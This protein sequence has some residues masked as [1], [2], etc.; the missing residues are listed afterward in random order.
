IITKISQAY[1]G[2]ASATPVV[3]FLISMLSLGI[4]G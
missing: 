1:A 3:N 4:E 2:R